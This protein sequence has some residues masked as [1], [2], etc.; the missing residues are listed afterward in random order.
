MRYLHRGFLLPTLGR[1]KSIEN[2]L[3]QVPGSTV[4]S[5]RYIELRPVKGIVEVWVHDLEDCGSE[6]LTDIGA[7]PSLIGE[8]HDRPSAAFPEAAGALDYAEQKCGALPD[9][10]VNVTMSQDDYLDFVRAGRP[11]KWP[12]A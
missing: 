9:R 1:G 2:F 5:V 12:V 6:A 7:F 10:W 11:K 3:G 4:P 8:H